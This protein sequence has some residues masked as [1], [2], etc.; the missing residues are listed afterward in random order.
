MVGPPEPGTFRYA[1]GLGIPCPGARL[2]SR[3]PLPQAQRLSVFRPLDHDETPSRSRTDRTL[4]KEENDA[5]NLKQGRPVR[6]V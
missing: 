3:T 6:S 5:H 2:Q 4:I 1:V